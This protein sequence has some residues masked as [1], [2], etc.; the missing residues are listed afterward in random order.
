MVIFCILTIKQLVGLTIIP[1]TT[2]Q[3]IG[4]ANRALIVAMYM[5]ELN[6]MSAEQAGLGFH[7]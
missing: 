4:I 1:I 5:H 2:G 7:H 6:G 3:C